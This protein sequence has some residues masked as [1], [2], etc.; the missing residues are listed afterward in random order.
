MSL[1]A[2]MTEACRAVGIEPP[3]STPPGRWIQTPAEGKGKGNGAGRVKIDPDRAGGVVW[4]WLTGESKR[5]RADG[6]S[7][8][9]T[10]A[11]RRA[12][13]ETAEADAARAR[14][15]SRVCEQIV[16]ACEVAP[17]PYLAR[18][19]FPDERGLTIDSVTRFLPA[20]QFGEAMARALPQGEGPMLVIPG[21]V[22]RAITTL[23]FITAEGDKRNILGGTMAGAS[24]RIATGREAWVCE[25]IATALTVRA[26]LRLLGRSATVLSAFAAN[27]VAKVA[28][29][30]DACIIAADHDRPLDQLGGLGTGEFYARGTGR[31]WV[32]PPVMGDFNDWHQA[33][34][35]RA[36]A[37]FIK[38]N[39]PA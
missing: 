18:K 36:V 3:R 22:G 25:G 5:F 11:Q 33:E 24:H 35:L 6:S 7:A 32:M 8:S 13:R 28:G 27:N 39:C 37:M 34:G 31:R 17:H 21:R 10:P 29:Q 14:E 38:E 23:Q 20:G 12:I 15:V 4:N 16:G 26:A 1:D 19:G 30:I 2:A 9:L